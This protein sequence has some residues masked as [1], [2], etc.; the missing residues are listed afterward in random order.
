MLRSFC[1]GSSDRIERPQEEESSGRG[2]RRGGRCE[3]RGLFGNYVGLLG[4]DDGC[5]WGGRRL[6]SVV[7]EKFNV[8]MVEVGLDL[9]LVWPAGD[10]RGGGRLEHYSA[11]VTRS[12]L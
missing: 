8:L 1:G 5:S 11:S 2:G 10:S 6:S 7:G 12:F 9:W 3:E 4:R